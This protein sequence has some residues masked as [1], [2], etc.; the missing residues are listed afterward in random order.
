MEQAAEVL[1]R[2][3]EVVMG[4]KGNLILKQG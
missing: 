3:E 4:I 2:P 1:E